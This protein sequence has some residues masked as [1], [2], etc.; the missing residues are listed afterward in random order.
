MD[1]DAPEAHELLLANS[2]TT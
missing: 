1:S 2:K